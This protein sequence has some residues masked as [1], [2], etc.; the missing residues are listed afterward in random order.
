MAV[1]SIG[2]RFGGVPRELTTLQLPSLSVQTCQLLFKPALT[3]AVLGAIESLLCARVTDNLSDD[4]Y[5]PNQELM[6]Q[7][8][9]NFITPIF[10]GMPAT[11]TIA[12]TITNAKSG[13]VSPLSG[14]F[15]CLT[16]LL[17]VLVAS[18]LAYHI[19]LATLSAILI[20]VAWNM[21][22]WQEFIRLKEFR[23]P[24][25]F[26]LL[27]VFFLT[28][29][30]DLAS[31]VEFGL[32]AACLTFIYRI[33]SLTRFEQIHKTNDILALRMFGALFFGAVGL[34]ETLQTQLP[35][36]AL[37]L[38]FKYLIYLDT[39]G[40]DALRHL[41]RLCEKHNL[42]LVVCGLSHQPKGM[43]ERAGLLQTLSER[44]HIYT[45]LEVALKYYS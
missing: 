24:Y 44:G 29:L 19:P 3:L 43:M 6:G 30:V 1:P 33:S 28:I 17:I 12:R 8:I 10:G 38:D 27:S 40:A 41:I 18:P 22:E 21:A 36:Q 15:H 7:G 42:T 5:D 39:S 23:P 13:G 32:L 20:F 2:T 16:L 34:L 26:I 37:L 25:R 4:R 35:K 11:G 45:S 9:A 31:A 14:M